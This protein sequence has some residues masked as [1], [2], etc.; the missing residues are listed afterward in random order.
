MRVHISLSWHAITDIIHSGYL[1]WGKQGRGEKNGRTNG[2]ERREKVRK[3]KEWEAT[4]GEAKKQA[5]WREIGEDKGAAERRELNRVR[6]MDRGGRPES[7]SDEGS[8]R[9]RGG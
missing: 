4:L 5:K 7:R 2:A 3:E 1:H 6:R 8:S 9:V